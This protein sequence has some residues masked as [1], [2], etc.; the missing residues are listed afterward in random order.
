[1]DMLYLGI[2]TWAN[3][4]KDPYLKAEECLDQGPKGAASRA[5]PVPSL[6]ECLVYYSH[7]LRWTEHMRLAEYSARWTALSGATEAIWN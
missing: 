1:M 3:I 6:A 4:H 7:W 2:F 5:I